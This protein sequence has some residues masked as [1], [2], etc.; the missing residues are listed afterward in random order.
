[1][2]PVHI[3]LAR[4]KSNEVISAPMLSYRNGDL[5]IPNGATRAIRPNDFLQ[6]HDLGLLPPLNVP[7]RAKV[8]GSKQQG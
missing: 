6:W 2:N 7:E 4:S 1:M 8:N 3:K 5:T